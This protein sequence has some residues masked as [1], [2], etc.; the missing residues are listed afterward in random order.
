MG[1]PMMCFAARFVALLILTLV[2]GWDPGSSAAQNRPG[3]NT[4]ARVFDTMEYRIR[5]V[6][7]AEGMPYPHSLALLPNGS[8]LLTQLNGQVRLIR[9]GVLE[10]EPVGRI[11]GVLS[12]LS[13]GAGSGG[14]MDI[15]LHPKFAENQ[16]VYFAYNKES[17]RGVTMAIAR[18]V[19]DGTRLSGDLVESRAQYFRPLLL[20]RR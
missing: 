9:N 14:L 10:P 8:I 15:A 19:F 3:A 16:N 17:E 5:L 11:P 1:A 6:T 20:Y 13:G 12:R 7:I 4:K 18:G 2:A